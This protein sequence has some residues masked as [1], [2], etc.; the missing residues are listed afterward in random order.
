MRFT[1]STISGC[2]AAASGT[3]AI[4]PATNPHN[5]N[6]L[7]IISGTMQRRGGRGVPHSYESF[8]YIL[9][10]QHTPMVHSVYRLWSLIVLHGHTGYRRLPTGRPR[11]LAPNVDLDEHLR[12]YSRTAKPPLPP[13]PP[14]YPLV[15]SIQPTGTTLER[16]CCRCTMHRQSP[17]G[18]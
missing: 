4:S 7:R 9:E 6:E 17:S 13:L 12:C 15:F 16:H 11:I 5:V 18:P 14:I 8:I 1:R 3:S 10:T 2:H